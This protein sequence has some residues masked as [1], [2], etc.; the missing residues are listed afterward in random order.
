MA[1]TTAAANAWA[2]VIIAAYKA[3]YDFPWQGESHMH[4]S[5]VDQLLHGGMPVDSPASTPPTSAPL[6]A[7]ENLA[8][9]QLVHLPLPD[10]RDGPRALRALADAIEAGQHGDAHHIAWVLDCGDG[11]VDI[12]MTGICGD[13]PHQGWRDRR[14]AGNSGCASAVRDCPAPP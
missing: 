14:R 8:T 13:S 5:I 7:A 4:D 12:G 10:I 2:D 6:A 3:H 1:F 9:C 11:R